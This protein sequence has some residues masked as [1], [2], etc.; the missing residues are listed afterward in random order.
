VSA[1]PHRVVITGVGLTTPLGTGLEV[2]ADALTTGKSGVVT[3]PEWSSCDGLV[4]RLGADVP[5]LPPDRIPRKLART[6]GRVSILATAATE[7]ALKDAGLTEAEVTSGKVGLAYGSTHG[8]TSAMESFCRPLYKSGGLMGLTASSY[9]KFMS[10]TCAANLAQHF[11]LRGRVIPTCSACTSAS[12]AIGAGY[13]AVRY[14]LE[15]VMVVGGAEEMHVMHAAVFDL[16][17]ATST[18]KNDRPT[19]S[20]RPFDADRDGLVVGEGAGT[21]V[22]ES[23]E[24]AHARGAKIYA[25]VLGFGTNCDGTHVTSP[26]AEGMRGAI[27][28]AL[29]DARLSPDAIDY[30]NAHGT[31]TELGDLAETAATHAVFGP[32]VPISSTKGATGHTLGA[33]GAIEAI[34]SLLMMRDGFMAPTRNLEKVDPRCAPLDYVMGAPREARLTTVMTNN[35]AFGGINTSIILRRVE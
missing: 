29:A 30:V 35:F 6:M 18:R 16:M 26:S 3:H 32:R 5:D 14:G 25:E 21:L 20:P 1:A 27:D 7:D 4:T 11:S 12:Q 28:R 24:R 19:E 10:H 17:Y 34:F 31:A 23:L 15:D 8:S 2:V 22:L 13:E 33:C 9:L